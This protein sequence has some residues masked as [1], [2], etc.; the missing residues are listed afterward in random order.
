[1]MTIQYY[2]FLGQAEEASSLG[3]ERRLGAW[4]GDDGTYIVERDQWRTRRGLL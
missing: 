2:K 4:S 1:M 3:G